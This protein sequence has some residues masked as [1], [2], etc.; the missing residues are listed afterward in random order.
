MYTR[1]EIGIFR[2]PKVLACFHV[3]AR[4]FATLWELDCHWKHSYTDTDRVT[5]A[6][7]VRFRV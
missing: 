1:R 4:A 2:E 6:C 3:L 5:G 7:R